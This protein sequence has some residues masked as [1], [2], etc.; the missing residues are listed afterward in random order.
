MEPSDTAAHAA[1]M[2]DAAIRG[3]L[4]QLAAALEGCDAA[5]RHDAL[6]DAEAHLRAAVRAGTPAERAIA[7]YGLPAEIA[8]AYR[9]ADDAPAPWRGG[10]ASA[11]DAA[12]SP[13]ESPTA[14]VARRRFRRL[15]V[16]GV[17]AQPEAWGA[18]LYFGVVGFVL[19]TAYFVWTVSIGGVALGLLPTL[20]G[21]PIFVAL[22][23][24]ARALCLFEGRVV[25]ALLGVRMPRR[26]Q[27]V[28]GADSVGFWQ[29][30]WCWLR[31][32]RSW[33][34]LAYL[35]GNFPVSVATFVI[36]L[37]LVVLSAVMLAVPILWGLGV[38]IGSRDGETD[39]QMQ[40]L[41]MQLSP[42]ERGDVWLPGGAVLPAFLAGLALMTATLWLMRGFGWVYGHV[43]QAIQVARPR[44]ALPPRVNAWRA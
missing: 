16:I 32:V 13:L 28:A 39:F 23:G 14:P 29:R 10:P 26:T 41:W 18:L 2:P 11:P 1:A 27:P 31:D 36:T 43:V 5:L 34:S 44:P 21:F 40:F 19:A 12:G 17:W 6:L 24:S 33:M 20:L 9:D 8:R 4:A 42:D 38:P 25:Q 35:L 15:P 3:Y 7:D 30:I 37:V 22:L